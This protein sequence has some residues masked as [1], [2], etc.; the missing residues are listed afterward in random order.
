VVLVLVTIEVERLSAAFL[1]LVAKV[2]D[3]LDLV[4]GLVANK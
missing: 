3:A 2:G 1:L 4:L